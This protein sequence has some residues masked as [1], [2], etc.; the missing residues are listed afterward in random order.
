MPFYFTLRTSFVLPFFILHVYYISCTI[1]CQQ[2][3]QRNL[4]FLQ[5]KKARH[6]V[7]QFEKLSK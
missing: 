6:K 4:S 3:L 7:E 1:V 2:F 5:N